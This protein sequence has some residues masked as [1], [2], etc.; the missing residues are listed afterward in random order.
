MKQYALASSCALLLLASSCTEMK[1]SMRAIRCNNYVV[2]L[3]TQSINENTAAIEAVNQEI[4]E[5]TKQLESINE[6][7][8]K[9][10]E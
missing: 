2:E 9:A 3:S 1:R 10:S 6:T 7:I 8:K 5:N 4:E